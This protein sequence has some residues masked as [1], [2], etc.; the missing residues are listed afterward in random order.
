MNWD[1]KDS[2]Q[3]QGISCMGKNFKSRSNI[4]HNLIITKDPSVIF[5][6]D[7][8]PTKPVILIEGIFERQK[9]IASKNDG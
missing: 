3:N 8:E 2:L 5:E 4:E 6:S 9:I 7:I 1:A